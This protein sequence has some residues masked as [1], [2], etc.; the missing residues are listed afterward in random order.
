MEENAMRRLPVFLI[1]L[2]AADFFALGAAQAE[3]LV[4]RDAQG[5]RTGT[6][7]I[8]PSGRQILRDAQGRR[9][10]TIEPDGPK[11]MVVRDAAG[12]RIG[13]QERQ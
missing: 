2:F 6:V 9:T 3:T 4:Q 10:G 11:R 13:T 1:L 8:E 7:E 5:R 12:R